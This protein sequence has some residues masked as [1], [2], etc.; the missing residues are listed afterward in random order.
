MKKI[1]V[2]IALSTLSFGCILPRPVSRTQVRAINSLN[3]Y[4]V[5]WLEDGRMV[6]LENGTDLVISQK[7]PQGVVKKKILDGIEVESIDANKC[8]EKQIVDCFKPIEH[9][10]ELQSFLSLEK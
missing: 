9:K 8:N 4:T 2:V 1:V 5:V 10:N 3:G 6:R 7:H